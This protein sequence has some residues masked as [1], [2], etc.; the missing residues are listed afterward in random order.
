MLPLCCLHRWY[1]VFSER[2]TIPCIPSWLFNTFFFFSRLKSHLTKRGIAGI[3]ALNGVQLDVCG[4]KCIDL[5]NEAIKVLGTYFSCKKTIKEE[6]NFFKI[7]SNC[8]Q[9]VSNAKTRAIWKSYSWW[10]NSCPKKFSNID[11]ENLISNSSKSHYQ[12]FRNNSDFLL[13]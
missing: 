8:F 4:I 11:F 6:S 2:F 13:M 3:E 7:I 9:V 5:R 12:I 10:K 1:N